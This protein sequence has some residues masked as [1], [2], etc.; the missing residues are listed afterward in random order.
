MSSGLLYLAIVGVWAGVLV[1]MWVRRSDVGDARGT[2]GAEPAD[3]TLPPRGQG[4]ARARVVARRRRRLS[5][6]VALLLVTIAIAAT[7]VA[8][9][10]IVP[11]PGVALIGYVACLRAA[12]VYDAELMERDRIR[13]ERLARDPDTLSPDARPQPETAGP[14]QGEQRATEATQ[15]PEAGEPD[16]AAADGAETAAMAEESADSARHEAAMRDPRV[17]DFTA[18][19][20]RRS[21]T[22][23][24]LFDQHADSPRRAVG[25]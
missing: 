19:T 12:A 4:R 11:V 10:W 24:E 1:P 21:G 23:D 22:K 5:G 2:S 16:D 13:A 25:D 9:W 15:P 6:I 14:G 17:I 8:P 7:G 3:V 18:A 20:T